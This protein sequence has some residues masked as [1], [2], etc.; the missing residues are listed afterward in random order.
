MNRNLFTALLL[1]VVLVLLI[2]PA[3]AQDVTAEPTVEVTPEPTPEQPPL[4]PPVDEPVRPDTALEQLAAF[5]GQLVYVSV[6][7][8]AL[9]TT[10]TGLTRKFLPDVNAALVNLALSVALWALYW[11]F[12]QT[13]QVTLFDSLVSGI[14][15]ILTGALGAVGTSLAASAIHHKAEQFDTPVLGYNPP[16]RAMKTANHDAV[17]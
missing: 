17:G 14:N 13:G 4:G 9:V 7:V 6:G 2:A 12:S 15:I 11:V 16:H 10:L 3:A 5:I 1:L 8:A